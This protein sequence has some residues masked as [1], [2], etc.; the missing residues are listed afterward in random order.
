MR[1]AV[2]GSF[3]R[4]ATV[5]E[6]H[7]PVMVILT[8]RA[9]FS[10]RLMHYPE[11]YR[12]LEAHQKAVLPM[13][14][15]DL[16]VII[17]QPA[18]L[19]DVQ[20]TFEWEL[21][22]DLLFESQGQPGALPLLEFTLA[23]LFERRRGHTLTRQAYHEMGGIK[24]ALARHAEETYASLPSEEHRRLVRA[25]FLRLIQPGVTEQDTTRRRASLSELRLPNPRETIIL[26]E[27]TQAFITARLLTANTITGVAMV[28]VSLEA[29]IREW[30][31]LAN[32]LREAREDIH[33]QQTISQDA[34]AWERHGKPGDHL[35][36]GAQLKD[37]QVWA[38]RNTP[39]RS[40]IAFLRASAL[41]RMLFLVSVLAVCL[42]LLSLATVAIQL[43]LNQ[44]PDPTRVT[45]P[46][47]NGTGSLRWAIDNAPAGSTITFD[48]RLRGKTIKL[49]S[50]DL[51]ITRN[52]RIRGLGTGSLTISSDTDNK[53]IIMSNNA[54]ATISNVM[55]KGTEFRLGGSGI[56]NSA[57]LTLINST[58][59]GNFSTG[60]TGGGGILNFKSGVLTM[61]NSTVEGNTSYENG[62][63]ISN[64]GT[65][66]QVA[67]TFCTIYGN[68]AGSRGGGIWNGAGNKQLVMSN[69]IVAGNTAHAGPDIR[70]CRNTHF[71]WLQPASGH[72]RGDLQ[73]KQAACYRCNSGS[74]R[75]RE[76]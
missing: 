54:V 69:S 18:V 2:F 45:N 21:V 20:L 23:Q 19:P 74:P 3:S 9:D 36:R 48:E 57:T 44:P 73:S 22:G 65:N 59:A 7:G 28:E 11:L 71:K 46:Q 34:A 76:N 33:L 32:W 62:G 42:L 1:Q 58:V 13:E 47:D 37:A 40:E 38:T 51:Q 5:T 4:N 56:I 55:L 43:A 16:R 30:A 67:I 63:G 27:V 53:S 35:Y 8:L 61:T 29:V 17:E 31:R 70:Y 39:S 50:G 64:E 15:G 66:T 26:E 6:P 68:R 14:I 12:L 10:D 49:T 60:Y 52:L 72:L 25:L 41:Q 75:R 24:G